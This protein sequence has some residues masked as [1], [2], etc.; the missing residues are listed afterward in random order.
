M[1]PPCRQICQAALDRRKCLHE[2]PTVVHLPIYL[3]SSREEAG[4]ATTDAA[5]F[6]LSE[7]AL[8]VLPKSAP[9]VSCAIVCSPQ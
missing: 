1:N 9:T 5:L 7:D 3:R 6:A 8:L 2:P 4:T